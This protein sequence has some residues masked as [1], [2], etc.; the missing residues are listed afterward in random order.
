M[1]WIGCVFCTLSVLSVG[2]DLKPRSCSEVRQAY[3]AKGF[4][5]VNVP[6]QE[7]S[8]MS[9]DNA[10]VSSTF[11]NIVGELDVMSQLDHPKQVVDA[12][13]ELTK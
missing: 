10:C 11:I 3:T 12:L 7:I 2:A 9:E 6:H 1:L 13:S 5:L 8:A 4:S